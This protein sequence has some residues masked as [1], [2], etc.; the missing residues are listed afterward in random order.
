MKKKS[1]VKR[2]VIIVG[3]IVL[4]LSAAQLVVL[5]AKG[6]I[7]PLKF[8]KDN[9]M[10]KLPGNAEEYH[11]EYVQPHESSPLEGKRFLFLGSSVTNGSASLSVSMADYIGVLNGCEIIKEA[12]NGTTLAGKG[13]NTYVA[14]LKT[15]DTSDRFDAV[16]CQLSTNDAT[17]KK[18]L[19]TISDSV[20]LE[21]FDT[22]TVIGALEYII[23][24]TKDT[25]GCPV[26]IYTGVKYDS[27]EYQAM[28][29]ALPA[30]QEKWGI[31]VIDLWND[32]DMNQV[33]EEDYALYMHDKIH[34]TQV[35]YLLWWVPKFE[36][37]LYELFGSTEG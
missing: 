15:V 25:W 13:N 17:Q 5:G 26:I 23:A 35:G 30:L 10:A 24:Y 1:K 7:G 3:C 2:N 19:G 22:E 12:V 28:V 14:R 27:A 18:E 31:S 34:P 4:V 8:I 11:L 20:R 37:C 6:G 33:S 21:D 32:A 9:K 16:V 29:D 36:R